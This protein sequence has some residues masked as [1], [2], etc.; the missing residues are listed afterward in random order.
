MYR[1]ICSA[2]YYILMDNKQITDILKYFF[3]YFCVNTHDNLKK[4]VASVL[5]K[6]FL[7]KLFVF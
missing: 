4:K 5:F 2:V 3:L 1:V 7:I 6:L